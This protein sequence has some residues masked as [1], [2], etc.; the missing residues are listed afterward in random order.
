M[1]VRVALPEHVDDP[2]IGL[3]TVACVQR[4]GGLSLHDAI[5]RNPLTRPATALAKAVLRP[6]PRGTHAPA[7]LVRPQ[8]FRRPLQG[9]S[10]SPGSVPGQTTAPMTGATTAPTTGPTTGPTT[11]PTTWPGPRGVNRRLDLILASLPQTAFL[12]TGHARKPP[13]AP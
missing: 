13:R 10:R 1:V 7:I 6:A 2:N 5:N 11:E 9:A 4:A 8:K 12:H 3:A